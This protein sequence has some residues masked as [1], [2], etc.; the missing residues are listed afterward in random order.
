VNCKTIRVHPDLYRRVEEFIQATRA[1]E[2]VDEYVNFV[3]ETLFLSDEQV[4]S[5]KEA[6]VLSERL[7][8]LGYLD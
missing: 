3:L 7:K 8:A 6:E 5:S 2:G 1:F 4:F